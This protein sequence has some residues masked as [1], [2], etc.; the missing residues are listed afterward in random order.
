MEWL[1]I[2]AAIINV[3]SDLTI[4]ML[5]MASVWSLQMGTKQKVGVSAVFAAGILYI[6]LADQVKE[7][8]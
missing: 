6:F 3:V 2:V 7:L 1:I 5:P 4:L 8:R